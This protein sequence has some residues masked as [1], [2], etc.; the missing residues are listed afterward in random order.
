[1]ARKKGLTPEEIAVLLRDLSDNESE[2]GE[3]SDIQDEDFVNCENENDYSSD[4]DES[5]NN[6]TTTDVS[7]NTEALIAPDGTEWKIYESGTNPGRF[8]K[9]NILRQDSGPTN[10]AKRN[11]KDDSV[12]SAWLLYIDSTILNNIKKCTEAE[13]KRVLKNDTWS[14]PIDELLAFIAILYARGVSGAKGI[15]LHSLWSNT[16][17]LNFCKETMGRNRFC[18]ILRFLRFDLKSTRSTRL[19]TDRFGMISEIW[20]RFIE[21]CITCFKP[22]ENI[23]IDEQLFPS[24]TRCPFTQFIPSKPDKYGQKFWLAV[25][26]RTKYLLNAFPYLG[27][28]EERPLNQRLSE[29]VVM[30]L[31]KPFLSKGL[32]VTVDNFF[33]SIHL[34]KELQQKGTSLVGTVSKARRE[35]PKSMKDSREELYKSKILKH[36]ETGATLTVYQ[37]KRKKNVMVM[38][39]LHASVEINNN[40][41]KT[42]ETISFYNAT[43]YGVDIIDQMARKYSVKAPSRRWPVH[44]F[45][46]MLDFA[47]INAWILFNEI[48]GKNI[49]RKTYIQ[50]L[51]DEMRQNYISLSKK[52]KRKA[53]TADSSEISGKKRRKCEIKLCKGN[54]TTNICM[55][56]KK[57]VCGKCYAKI[58]YTC[59][60]CLPE[61]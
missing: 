54:M 38:S 52:Q 61:L 43:K 36:R 51:V 53:S 11:V 10:H 48:T 55:S 22:G 26:V 24:K 40:E 20:N 39:T 1:M 3:L 60:N 30:R 18:E 44:T 9:Q 12:L 7:C 59:K 58:D 49:T 32:N 13:A 28:N 35:I 47:A 34:A 41:K 14:L 27:K 33:T 15:D 46:N 23:T 6:E 29:Y 16:W 56:C 8:P 4:S 42:P 17:G 25:D 31:M 19:K 45:Y 2:G 5:E 50:M 57:V 37:G 21:N